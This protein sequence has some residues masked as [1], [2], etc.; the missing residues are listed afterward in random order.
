MYIEKLERIQRRAVKW[1]LS[2]QNHHY[3]N[4]EYFKRLKDLDL[5][6]F[7]YRFMYSDLVMFYKIY[8]NEICVKLPG[9]YK[10]VTME[11]TNRLRKIIKPPDYLVNNET[12]RLGNMRQT[13]ND[14][15]SVKCLADAH[16][17]AFRNSFFF[18]T[19]QEWNR[20]PPEIRSAKSVAIFEKDLKSY[21]WEEAIRMLEPD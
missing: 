16:H 8:N 21:L 12:I 1:I 9:Y 3:N 15:L 20:V 13:K 5:L 18:R 7:W 17:S 14:S 11:D 10:P 2:E 19:F 4:L 6:P